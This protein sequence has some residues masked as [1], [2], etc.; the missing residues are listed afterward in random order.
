MPQ[1]NPN[2]STETKDKLKEFLTE[3]KTKYKS[4]NEFVEKAINTLIEIEN[5]NG[6]Q[7]LNVALMSAVESIIGLSEERITNRFASLLFSQAITIDILMQLQLMSE[8]ITATEIDMMRRE[9]VERIQQN[10]SM[11][12][13]RTLVKEVV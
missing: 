1:I 5:Q 3:N 9:A 10:K 7:F 13:F 2:V 11:P 12:D 6:N 4:Q 8:T